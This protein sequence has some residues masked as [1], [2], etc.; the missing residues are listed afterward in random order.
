MSTPTFPEDISR[1]DFEKWNEYLNVLPPRR[2]IA[3]ETASSFYV[4]EPIC[5]KNG[6]A[7]YTVCVK[8]RS[9]YVSWSSPLL[10]H[11]ELAYTARE[12]LLSPCRW[13]VFPLRSELVEPPADAENG[14]EAPEW[15]WEKLSSC[16]ILEEL[17]KFPT[18][19]ALRKALED[20]GCLSRGAV[21]NLI[22]LEDGDLLIESK[23]EGRPICLIT[24]I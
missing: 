18:E 17:G 19:E 3:E 7:I 10:S 20:A 24:L 16:A 9:Q 11:E 14:P 1:I 12:Y 23:E 6:K 5:F 4:D 13:K 22:K 21:V 15:E 8:I 2:F